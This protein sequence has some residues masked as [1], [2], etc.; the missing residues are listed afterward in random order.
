[1][2]SN[3]HPSPQPLV[4]LWNHPTIIAPSRFVHKSLSDWACNI[5]VGCGHQCSVCYVPSVSTN[6]LAQPLREHGVS[7]PDLEWGDYAFIRRWDE[8]EFLASLRRAENQT[9]RSRDGHRAVLFSSTTDSYQVIRH[10]DPVQQQVLNAILRQTVRRALVLI[11]DFSTLRVRILTRSPLAKEDFELFK[12]F[13]PRLMFGMSL[14][15]LRNDLSKVYELHAPAPTQRL[16]TLQE[17]KSAGLNVFVAMAATY[18]ESDEADLRKT[19]QAI[20]ALEPMTVFH[21]VVNIRAEN[22]ARLVINA[23]L[24]GMRVNTEVYESRA[25]WMEY[26]LGTFSIVERIAREVGLRQRLHLWPDKVLGS[27]NALNFVS[28]PV[29]YQAWLHQCWNRISEWP[30]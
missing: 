10:P 25:A 27:K 12:S 7:D 30:K 11:R 16:K 2:Q 15:T 18:P 9:A 17:A 8:E 28:D 19:M 20:A 3:N 13:G 21:E 14:P 26:A 6:K 24:N 23:A 22:V 1:M 5:A 4:G 29:R